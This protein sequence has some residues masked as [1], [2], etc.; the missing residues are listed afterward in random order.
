MCIALP[1]SDLLA[2]SSLSL[3]IHLQ[4]SKHSC[5]CWSSLLCVPLYSYTIPPTQI[6]PAR[7][8]IEDTQASFFP[9]NPVS[10]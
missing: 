6:L 9:P 4:T 3:S 5:P 8:W 1:D 2:C 7:V 10:S